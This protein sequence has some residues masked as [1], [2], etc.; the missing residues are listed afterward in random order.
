M[1]SILI[2]LAVGAGLVLSID[3]IDNSFKNKKEIENFLKIPVICAI[4]L[5]VTKSEER[6]KRMRNIIGYS[7]FAIWLVFL[8]AVTLYLRNKGAVIL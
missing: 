8:V 2:G 7:F 3:F 1:V 6:R 5:I 4:P